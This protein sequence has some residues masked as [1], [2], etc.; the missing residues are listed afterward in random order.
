MKRLVYIVFFI[1]GWLSAQQPVWQ[2]SIPVEPIISAETN[3]H[4]QAFLWIPENC[5]HINGVVIGQHNM[6][7]EGVLEHSYFRKKM[8]EIGF[9][10][11]WVTPGISMVYHHDENDVASF[12]NMLKKLAETSGYAELE[13]API[14]PIGHSAYA[15][16]P[17]N[18][19][20]FNNN[21]TLTLVS[22][23]GDAPQTNLTGSGK[24]NPDWGINNIDGIPA[25]F[26]M[27]EYEWWEK[28]IKPGF[29]YVNK[30]PKS[31]ITFFADAGHGHFDASDMLIKYIA[32]YIVKAAKYRNTGKKDATGR[33]LLRLLQPEQGWLGDR[34]HKDSLPKWRP[35][36]YEN[37]KGDRATASWFFDK[38]QSDDTEQYYATSRGKKQQYIGFSQ[39][40]K[41][42]EP[43]KTHANYQL[44]FK[45]QDDGVSFSV[46]AL[47]TDS[48]KLKPVGTC[49]KTPLKLDRI[50]GPVQKVNDSVFK[51]SFYR[52]GFNNPKR[53]GDIWLIAHNEG[54]EYYKSAVQ[55]LNLRIPVTNNLG[56]EQQITFPEI[57]NSKADHKLRLN[58]TSSSG[59]QIQYYVKEGPSYIDDDK[60]V[61][62]PIPPRAKFPVKVT[63]VAWQYGIAGKWQSAQPIERTFYLLK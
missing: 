3:M 8:A 42:I 38:S 20:A 2:W 5:K 31:V 21:R 55:Q 36:R 63:V 60:V 46:T 24:P 27:G 30:H 57:E 11:I 40:E 58:A 26:I 25:L 34:W 29:D 28:R 7:E 23:H 47:Y 45:P 4:P 16:F 37:Y 22:V 53:S 35:A 9:A 56:A 17:W 54:D 44:D 6:T 14:V 41:I 39:N 18:F 43:K 49:A 50:C 19:A 59:L 33:P 15:S 10:E 1:S 13:F 62:T 61:F 51:I 32:D 48:L 52:M 12:S